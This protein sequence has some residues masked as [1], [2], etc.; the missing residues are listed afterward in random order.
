MPS[1]PSRQQLQTEEIAEF[2]T[3]GP[4]GGIQSE[5]PL[6]EIEGFGF[7]DIT[8]FILRRGYASVRPGWTAL[9]PFPAP[10]NEPILAVADFFNIDGLHIQC[11]ITPTR[12][13][14][15]ISGGWTQ[16]T[17]P[18][19]GGTSTDL[20]SWDVL[21]YK[22]CFSQGV[23]DI[24]MW[25]GVASTY[26][27]IAGAPP[28]KYLAE[29]D[30]HLIAVNPAFPQR[31]Y[32]SGI[33][34]PTDWTSFSS[35]LDDN[36]SN[37]GPINWVTKLGQYGFGF[38]QKGV[39][40]II[41]TGVGTAPFDFVPIL[42]AT[43]GLLAPYSLDI[44]DDQGEEI[45]IFLGI[46][47][48]YAFNGT[49][50]ESIGDMPMNDGSRRRL[51]A[52][53]RILVDVLA[54]NYAT[55]YGFVT[56]SLNGQFFRAYWLVIPNVSVWVYNFDETNWTRFTYN[57]T[58]VSIGNFFK[59]QAIRIIDLIG[60]IEQQSWAPATLETNNPFEGLL[61]GFSDGTGGYV[62][63]TNYSEVNASIT[64]G[65]IIFGD[66][67]HKHTTKKYRLAVLDQGEADYTLTITNEKNISESHTITLGSG[68][69][70]VLSYVQ[71]FK[72]T[73]LRITWQ[74]S[75]PAGQPGSVVEVA[76]Y[77]DVGGEQRGGTI[78]N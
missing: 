66:R 49:S 33:G 14:Q 29:V 15:Y 38:H 54:G 5:L 28:A 46:D 13:L 32:W 31:Y 6:T 76:P 57:K 78:D 53:S 22:L 17:G 3:T 26:T 58:I 10:A 67:R 73:G 50:I 77:Y 62:D 11:V 61:L 35:G 7:S 42:N 71:E 60:T 59:N 45:A 2:P 40:Q 63:F 37:L 34:D 75:V 9:P 74:I 68:S 8:N 16:I 55:I 18:A 23:D 47:N 24:F 36:V 25:D 56:Y 51:G 48:V 65:K 43:Q 4:F 39:L 30:L 72:V 27:Q 20:F 52:R 70:D 19:F 44:L 41:P 1:V 69:G 21:N 12:L 64:S